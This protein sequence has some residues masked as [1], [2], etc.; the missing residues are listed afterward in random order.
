M[1]CILG[2]TGN[3]SGWRELGSAAVSCDGNG[4]AS[5][6]CLA[7]LNRGSY[8]VLDASSNSDKVQERLSAQAR[9]QK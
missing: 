9:V 3:N 8:S 7:T 5:K 6:T 4:T 2:G 1:Q